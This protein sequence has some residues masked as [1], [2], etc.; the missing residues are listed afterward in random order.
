MNRIIYTHVCRKHCWVLL[1]HQSRVTTLFFCFFKWDSVHFQEWIKSSK[2]SPPL[3]WGLGVRLRPR[4]WSW[5]P[6]PGSVTADWPP[7]RQRVSSAW[8]FPATPRLAEAPSLNMCGTDSEGEVQEFKP[9]LC[10][11]TLLNMQHYKLSI[12][13]STYSMFTIC[14]VNVTLVIVHVILCRV[15]PLYLISKDF[16]QLDDVWVSLTLPQSSNLPLGVCLHPKIVKRNIHWK[17]YSVI[18]T[19]R[20]YSD[21]VTHTETHRNSKLLLSCCSI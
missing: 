13:E 16:M 3:V 6:R 11:C 12:L 14:C 2:H 8:S 21:T 15:P 9:W 7:P 4:A 19:N 5:Q 10:C 18:Y 1:C 20:W 17:K